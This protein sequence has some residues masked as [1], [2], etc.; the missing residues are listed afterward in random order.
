VQELFETRGVEQFAESMGGLLERPLAAEVEARHA[1][2][3]AQSL[4]EQRRIEASDDVS[5]ETYRQ[6][7]LGQDLLSGPH[8]RPAG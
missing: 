1:R 5:F 2:L 3:A 4:E 6:R 8:F 7:Y